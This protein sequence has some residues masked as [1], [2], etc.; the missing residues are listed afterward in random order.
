MELKDY[1]KDLP[2]PRL[3]I[4]WI[5]SLDPVSHVEQLVLSNV[6]IQ[7]FFAPGSETKSNLYLQVI[8]YQLHFCFLMQNDIIG[9]DGYGSAHF[10]PSDVTLDYKIRFEN[11]PNAT[12]PAQRVLIKHQLDDDLDVRSFRIGSFGFGDFTRDVTV[13][14]AFLQVSFKFKYVVIIMHHY[15]TGREIKLAK[16]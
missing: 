10:I 14:R 3:L 16:K 13:R 11:D 6:H 2:T 8:V 1:L 9:P 12:A 15:T 7:I 5:R 4:E